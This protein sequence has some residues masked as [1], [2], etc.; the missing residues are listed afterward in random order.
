MDGLLTTETL[1]MLIPLAMLQLSLA[2]Y[3]TNKIIKEGVSVLNK[4]FWIIVCF[5]NIT[6]SLIFLLVGRRKEQN[7]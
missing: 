4:W 7:D 5:A 2:A 6:G 1:I 3:C